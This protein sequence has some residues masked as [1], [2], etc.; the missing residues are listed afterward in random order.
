VNIDTVVAA[1]WIKVIGKDCE[2]SQ[3]RI[4]L[5]DPAKRGWEEHYSGL[6]RKSVT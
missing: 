4:E 6:K 3:Y 1:W 2:R 5:P